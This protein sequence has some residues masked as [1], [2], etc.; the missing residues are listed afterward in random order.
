MKLGGPVYYDSKIVPPWYSCSECGARGLRLWRYYSAFLSDQKL[1]C[2]DCGVKDQKETYTVDEEGK[3]TD[4]EYGYRSDQIGWLVPAV[5]T[6]GGETFWGYTSVS[7]M[8]CNWWRGLPVR[9]DGKY[10]MRVR[11]VE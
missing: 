7:E 2:A 9:E 5:P 10:G 4:P 1:F 3:H 8:G 6:E 11:G